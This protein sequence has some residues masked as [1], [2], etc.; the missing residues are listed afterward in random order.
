MLLEWEIAHLKSAGKTSL[1]D[2]KIRS[3]KS[4]IRDKS[5][6]SK[7][8]KF[9]TAF[10]RIYFRMALKPIAGPSA[11]P[12]PR[13]PRI[14][15]TKGGEKRVVLQAGAEE[16]GKHLIAH[17]SENAARH[18]RETDNARMARDVG[19]RLLSSILVHVWANNDRLCRNMKKPARRR[20]ELRQIDRRRLSVPYRE[21]ITLPLPS[22]MVSSTKSK[23]PLDIVFVSAI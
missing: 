8:R 17:E 3:T 14:E 16:N 1:S 7:I 19:P 23:L 10:L 20:G 11:K 12:R 2:H 21:I 5:K 4:E 13:P 15:P 18:D 22:E 9:Q 6:Y